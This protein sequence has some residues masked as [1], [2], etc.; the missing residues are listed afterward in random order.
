MDVQDKTK[1]EIEGKSSV[2]YHL[3]ANHVVEAKRWVW[4]LNNAIQWTKDEAKLEEKHKQRQVEALRQTKNDRPS[5]RDVDTTDSSKTNG[6]GVTFGTPLTA[7]TSRDS[8]S[9]RYE[10]V[11]EDDGSVHVPQDPSVAPKDPTPSTKK[12]KTTMIAGDLDG[13]DEYDDDTSGIE[14]QPTSKDAFNITAHSASLQLSLL[15]QVSAALQAEGI[16]NP[17]VSIS[18]PTISQAISTYEAA[19]RSLQGLVGDLLKISRDRDAYWQYRLDREADVRKMWEDS[20]AKVAKEQEELEG[21]IG[22]SEDKRKRTKRALR[23]ALEGTSAPSSQAGSRRTTQSQNQLSESLLRV[24]LEKEAGIPR[25]KSLVKRDSMR[26]KSTI[27]ELTNLSDSDSDEDEEFFDAVDAGEVE[28]V[29]EMP[30]SP[31]PAV[32]EIKP[33]TPRDDIRELKKAEIIASYKG[34]ED[35]VRTRLKMDQ[36]DRPKISLWVY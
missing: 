33:D 29:E 5:E 14:V 22:E 30:L 3:K 13:D 21:R 27:A 23:E 32:T 11:V 16:Q 10:V 9:G 2:K 25:R 1:F 24:Q 15:S 17:T 26:R 20:M 19:V 18:H 7:T 35:A 34:Y 28:I 4:A 6:R 12:T 31:P 8:L 36:D